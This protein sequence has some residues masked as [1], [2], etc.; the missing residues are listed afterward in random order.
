MFI[1]YP[2]DTCSTSSTGTKCQNGGQ[3]T[4]LQTSRNSLCQC[5]EGF[6]GSFC[7][8]AISR[9]SEYKLDVISE[10]DYYTNTPTEGSLLTVWCSENY[11][12]GYRFAV[13]QSNG[14]GQQP[15]WRG[16]ERCTKTPQTTWMHDNP[17]RVVNIDIFATTPGSMVN[18][19]ETLIIVVLLSTLGTIIGPLL[20]FYCIDCVIKC[21]P[22]RNKEEESRVLTRFRQQ[23]ADFKLRHP[24][25]EADYTVETRLEYDAIK[26]EYKE[27]SKELAERR[28]ER[29]LK[30]RRKVSALRI[31]SWY[32]YISWCIWIT[33]LVIISALEPIA[34]GGVRDCLVY[35]AEAFI[36]VLPVVVFVECFFSRE[37]KLLMKLNSI[38]S[39]TTTIELHRLSQP[40]VGMKASCFHYETRTHMVRNSDGT[41][42]MATYSVP[43]TTNTFQEEFT[44]GFWRDNS[45]T[46]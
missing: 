43:V 1:E 13:C 46:N 44:Y 23:V 42:Q 27:E 2:A 14:Y 22:H 4:S 12:P 32:F 11:S 41:M 5:A 21:K 28:S 37:K 31:H 39:A 26:K 25:S 38:Q 3:C 7:E 35:T 24:E 15:S 29:K 45:E 20:V 40:Y 30:Q 36:C 17:G 33:V 18:R 9:C 6:T 16:M 19:L 8:R 34:P 10:Y